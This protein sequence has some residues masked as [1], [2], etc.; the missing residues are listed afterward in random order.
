MAIE[1]KIDVLKAL[2]EAGYSSAKLRKE[3]IIGEATIQRLRHKQTVSFDVLSKLCC[4]LNCD[5]GDIL[6]YI[7]DD[8]PYQG[9]N[10]SDD[11]KE[12]W[13]FDFIKVKHTKC[14]K[15]WVNTY[16]NQN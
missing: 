10:L 1:Y 16:L 2:K 9:A 15:K 8:T 5:I 6:V 7:K 3:K 11:N 4:L 13:Y 12:M 14:I